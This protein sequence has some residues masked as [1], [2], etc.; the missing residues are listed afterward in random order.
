M[1]PNEARCKINRRDRNIFIQEKV[2]QFVLVKG[3]MDELEKCA[4]HNRRK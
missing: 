2:E 4:K 3:W 1:L